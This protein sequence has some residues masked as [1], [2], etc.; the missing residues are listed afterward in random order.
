MKTAERFIKYVKIDTQ[1]D[2]FSETTPTTKK[3]KELGNVLVSEL[4]QLGV[5]NAFMDEYGRIYGKIAGNANKDKIGFIAHM[6]TAPDA[7]GK[8]VQPRIVQNYDGSDIQLNKDVVMS[9]NEFP[10]LLDHLHEDL[11]VTDG[12]TL[13]GGDDKA[14]IAI[15]MSAIERINEIEHGDISIAFTCDEEVGRGADHFNYEYFDCDYAYTVDGDDVN[16]VDY[17][18]FN[19]V[20]AI[21]QITG[22]S[23]HPGDAKNKMVNASLVGMQFHSCLNEYENPACTSGYE[24][25]NHLTDFDGKCEGARLMYILRNHDATKLQKQIEQFKQ[26]TLFLN[27]KLGYEAIQLTLKE[28]YQNMRNVIEKDMRCVDKAKQAIANLGLNP[29]SHAIRGGT[30]GSRLT[31]EGL[32]TPNLGTGGKNCH[33]KYEYVSIQRMNQMV[34]VVLEIMKLA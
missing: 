24:G 3:Q 9:P 19:A 14:G 10:N 31:M 20:E 7:S 30:D 32:N 8:N 1:S 12:T 21:V 28:Q 18:N 26:A 25:F 17:E 6:D 34:D 16:S 27:Q 2:E 23:I 15:I 11:I 33:G 13:L 5:G 4:I 22:K 29:V